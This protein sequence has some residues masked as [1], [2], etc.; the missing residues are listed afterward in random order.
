MSGPAPLF[1]MGPTASGKT[2]LALALAERCPVEII[3]VDSTLIYRGMDI[4]TAKPDAATLAR[5]PHHLI[6][7]LDPAEAYSA[8]EFRAHALGLIEQ[9]QGRGRIPLL[10][11]GTLL[12]FRALEFGLAPL[13]TADAALRQRLAAELEREGGQALHRRLAQVDPLAAGRI[14]PNDPQRLLRALEVFELTGRPLSAIQAE[15]QA[16]LP[17]RPI[18]L[19]HAPYPREELR[20]RIEQRFLLMLEQGLEEEVR[21]LWARGDLRPDLPSMRALG[22]RQMLSYLR[23]EI[24]RPRMIER[25]V[26]ATR[27]LAKR[28]MTWLRGYPELVWLDPARPLEQALEICVKSC[29]QSR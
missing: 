18:R 26:T 11:G 25:A 21:R 19:A 2:E 20:Q 7:I 8:A 15:T 23:G 13:P 28:Q 16:A 3:S 29:I 14:H 27:Q 24:D 1:L 22:Y 9:I 6:D 5:I 17:F 10:V 4:G 12:Y